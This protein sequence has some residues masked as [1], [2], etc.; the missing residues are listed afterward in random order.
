MHISRW[1][2]SPSY[3]RWDTEYQKI[4]SHHSRTQTSTFRQG[5]SSPVAKVSDHGKH[6]MSSST[7]PLKTHRVGQGWADFYVARSTRSFFK[8][9]G[10]TL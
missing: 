10:S 9:L 4:H 8:V 5:C 2:R 6:V 7:V 3:H 1:N